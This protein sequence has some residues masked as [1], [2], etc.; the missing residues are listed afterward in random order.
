MVSVRLY[1]VCDEWRPSG[2]SPP[3]GRKVLQLTTLASGWAAELGLF[4][5][6]E[7]RIQ[8]WGREAAFGVPVPYSLIF[9]LYVKPCCLSLRT[10]KDPCRLHRD[11]DQI[12]CNME[13]WAKEQK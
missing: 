9:F 5:L 4:F 8:I 7:R 13:Q 12:M 11:N 3:C 2:V 1:H 6:S 10:T